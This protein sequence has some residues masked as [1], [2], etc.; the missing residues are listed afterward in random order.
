M[1]LPTTALFLQDPKE[2]CILPPTCQLLQIATGEPYAYS[3]GNVPHVEHGVSFPGAQPGSNG[4]LD[5]GCSSSM[6][7][8]PQQSNSTA[9]R[10]VQNNIS[11]QA[12]ILF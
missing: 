6:L 9:P 12:L 7:A 1:S 5:G 10:N 8:K 4:I 2:L 11:N 3:K